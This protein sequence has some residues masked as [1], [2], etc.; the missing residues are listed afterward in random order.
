[1]RLWRAKRCSP[2]PLTENAS[3]WGLLRGLHCYTL[4]TLHGRFE[5]N[6]RR[7]EASDNMTATS[8]PGKM[9]GKGVLAR[10]YLMGFTVWSVD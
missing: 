1:M 6:I 5:R 8:L 3:R 7:R 10:V 2:Q 4:S 9:I